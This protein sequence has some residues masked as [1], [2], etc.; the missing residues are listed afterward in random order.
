MAGLRNRPGR[1]EERPE[2]RLDERPEEPERVSGVLDVPEAPAEDSAPPVEEPVVEKPAAP[3]AAPS[4]GEPV[5]EESA[6]PP[7]DEPVEEQ[8]VEERAEKPAT[9]KP[10]ATPRPKP[11]PE[12]GRRPEGK[13]RATG[14]TRPTNLA[15]AER[16]APRH[17]KAEPAPERT[18]AR[19]QLSVA[20][21]LV[22]VAVVLAGLAVWFRTEANDL[23]S[24]DSNTAL[25]DPA[26]TSQ[27]VG[28]L[29]SAVEKT[30]SYN[31]TDL[32]ATEKAVRETLTGKALCD[33][34]LLFSEL[35]ELATQQK[36]ILAT[37]VRKI[38]LVRL[39]GDRAE[40]LVFIDQ[41][42]TR[43]DL[44]KS[45]VVGARFGVLAHRDGDQ[46]KI[47]EFNMFGQRLVGNRP[48]PQC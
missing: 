28:Q 35:K 10:R 41:N 8:P 7:V 26:G 39:D 31:Y 13:R 18:T 40:A 21:V 12:A 11:R 42:S 36:V 37:T 27:V 24:A 44:N 20:M 2:E 23:T 25:T 19:R 16:A 33:Y 45:A 38:G 29:K 32:A 6:A 30:F 3:P 9:P 4:A 14:A 43:A 22:V 34:N 17:A 15:E 48:L 1:P 46:W 5:A 47:T